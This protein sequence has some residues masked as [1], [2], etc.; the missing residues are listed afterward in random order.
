MIREIDWF[1]R[2]VRPAAKAYL[3]C[4]RQAWRAIEDP[5]LRITFDRDIRWRETELE[6]CAGDRGEA[7]LAPGELLM[8]IKTPTAAPL[9]LAHALSELRIFP[10]SFSKYGTC[11]K[12][13]ILHEYIFGGSIHA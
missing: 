9:W 10:V 12:E 13:H 7:L 8:E 11:Y 2:S 1:L 3:A 5:E 4:D 6:L